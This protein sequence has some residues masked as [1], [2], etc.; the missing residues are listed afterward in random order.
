MNTTNSNKLNKVSRKMIIATFISAA[1]AS[2]NVSAYESIEQ[3]HLTAAE[4]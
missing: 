2:S 3:E 1:I 4:K